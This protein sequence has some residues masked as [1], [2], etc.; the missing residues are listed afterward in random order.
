MHT[1]VMGTGAG[2]VNPKWE[3]EHYTAV[4]PTPES[5]KGIAAFPKQIRAAKPWLAELEQRVK[6]NLSDKPLVLV[7]GTK[8]PVFRGILQHW[9]TAF[10]QAAVIRLDTASPYLQEDE[11]ERIAEAIANAYSPNNT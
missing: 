11:P 8:D 7:W 9:E 5:R 10:P 2:R 4:V 6:A 1:C 3:F